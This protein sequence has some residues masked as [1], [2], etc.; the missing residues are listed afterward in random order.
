MSRSDNFPV[1]MLLVSIS[2]Y[3][4]TILFLELDYYYLLDRKIVVD[5]PVIFNQ[6][7]NRADRWI[8]IFNFAYTFL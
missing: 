2:C 1:S 8:E 7:G 3:T 6:I 4:G 5:W